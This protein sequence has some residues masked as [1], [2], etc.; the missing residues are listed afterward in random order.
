MANNLWST[1]T[2]ATGAV[3]TN[4]IGIGTNTGAITTIGT[5]NIA[6]G[7][8]G[9]STYTIAQEKTTYYILGEY[10]EVKGWSDPYLTMAIS[11]LNILKKPYYEE[12]RKNNFK[13]PTEIEE[14]LKIAFRDDIIDE[15]MKPTF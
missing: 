5:G 12:L 15:I 11:T 6:L 10:V 13:F 4:T 2:T 14:Y 3:T 7:S 1:T 9:T 8:S